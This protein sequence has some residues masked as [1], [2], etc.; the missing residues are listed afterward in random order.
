MREAGRGR[1]AIG[2]NGLMCTL[3]SRASLYIFDRQQL[4]EMT[5]IDLCE[6]FGEKHCISLLVSAGFE[7]RTGFGP[8]LH[9]NRC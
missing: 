4:D 3:Q 9:M 1:R 5:E 6:R 2:C 8:L 7:P